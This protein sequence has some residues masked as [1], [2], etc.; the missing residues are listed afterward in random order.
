MSTFYNG[1]KKKALESL[2]KKS[3]QK[4]VDVVAEVDLAL[5]GFARALAIEAGD[6]LGKVRLESFGLT[7]SSLPGGSVGIAKGAKSL[8][9]CLIKN[10]PSGCIKLGQYST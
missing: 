3:E 4:N 5:N 6:D 8:V 10:L 1:R 2:Y 7:N 9:E